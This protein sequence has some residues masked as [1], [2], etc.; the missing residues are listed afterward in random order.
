[1]HTTTEVV[2]LDARIE[3]FLEK[4]TAKFPDLHQDARPKK[5]A[6]LGSTSTLRWNPSGY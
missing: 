5:E 1:M 6:S 2:E 3:N 4:K